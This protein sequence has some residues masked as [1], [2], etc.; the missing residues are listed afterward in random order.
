MAS[1]D[2]VISTDLIVLGAS[3][4]SGTIQGTIGSSYA[5]LNESASGTNPTIAPNRQFLGT[6]ISAVDNEGS[7]TFHIIVDD[8]SLMLLSND[9]ANIN[10]VLTT[11]G[12]LFVDGNADSIQLRIDAHST[13]NNLLL[14][15]RDSSSAAI[16]TIDDDGKFAFS[17]VG[18]HGLS[19]GGIGNVQVGISGEYTSIGGGQTPSS[20]AFDSVLVGNS[21][22]SRLEAFAIFTEIQVVTSG[23]VDDVST[24]VLSETFTSITGGGSVTREQNL[25]IE[26]I[27]VAGDNT[28]GIRILTNQAGGST[29][30]IIIEADPL[31]GNGGLDSE[32]IL[33]RA[34]SFAAA[35]PHAMDWKFFV[36]VITN[37][38]VSEWR[39]ENRLDGASF[40]DKFVVGSDGGFDFPDAG[41]SVEAS[42]T[43]GGRALLTQFDVTGTGVG[44]VTAVQFDNFV[45]G[46]FGDTAELSSFR[47][48]SAIETPAALTTDAV[49]QMV[50]N[51]PE[52]SIG[53][54]G[55]LTNESVIT[56]DRMPIAGDNTYGLRIVTNRNDQGGPGTAAIFMGASGFFGGTGQLDSDAIWQQGHSDDG[57][58][59]VAD[60]KF[61]TGL[62]NDD[63]SSAWTLQNQLD[64]AGFV[65]KFTIDDAG[66]LTIPGALTVSGAGPHAIAGVTFGAIQLLIG[67][68]FTSDGASNIASGLFHTP[69]IVGAPGD[70]SALTGTTLTAGITTQTATESITNIAQLQINEP[71]ITDNL[72]GDI[73][74]AQTLLIT[75]APTEGLSNFAIRVISG[76]V[77]FGGALDV[78]G[79]TTTFGRIK[80]VTRQTTTYTIL[81][82]DSVVFGNTDSAGFTA[83]LPAGVS[84]Q[85]F[86]VVNSGSSGNI[87]TVTPDGSEDLLG[88]NSSFAL[89]D[90]EALDITFD[91]TDGWY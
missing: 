69:T 66:N 54:A 65:T 48:T 23:V 30:A 67:G 36:N 49:S 68:T 33:L 16:F 15:V 78:T 91:S 79:T 14:R 73:T 42:P 38:G 90:G 59:H 55:S 74:N 75:G 85:T 10:S 18:P 82:T 51:E 83:T 11:T 41:F 29:A 4:F 60:W 70:T 44:I 3:Q 1:N 20:M 87:L 72:T 71:F 86:K 50:V 84:G 31:S 63:G 88:V 6:G 7:S 76:S 12:A 32:A 57:S 46:I 80:T 34:Q 21:S 56:I 5:L 45:L 13:Q 27:G 58:G 19:G 24:M 28:Y 39:L 26:R 61:F 43:V 8:V 17:G 2:F 52:T 40:A 89:F 64:G 37:A 47:I 25:L 77:F 22:D 9:S 35:T 53:A 81:V 62:T